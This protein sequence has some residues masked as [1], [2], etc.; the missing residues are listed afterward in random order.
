MLSASRNKVCMVD[1][2]SQLNSLHDDKIV[3]YIE[4]DSCIGVM[5]ATCYVH[6]THR[7][8]SGR[9]G[10]VSTGGLVRTGDVWSMHHRGVIVCRH[11]LDISTRQCHEICASTQTRTRIVCVFLHHLHECQR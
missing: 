5:V 8:C 4:F 3:A 2:K 7:F 10:S 11:H 6:G 9:G 1:L